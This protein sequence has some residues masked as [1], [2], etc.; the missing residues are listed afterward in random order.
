MATATADV[1]YSSTIIDT[2]RPIVVTINADQ[3]STETCIPYDQLG[4]VADNMDEMDEE[5]FFWHVVAINAVSL[6]GFDDYTTAT[7]SPHIVP[8]VE[9]IEV[10]IRDGTSGAE[11]TNVS[12]SGATVAENAGTATVSLRLSQNAAAD[13]TF[14]VN[15]ADGTGTGGT[16]AMAPSD[17][18]ALSNFDVTVPAGTDRATF[19]IAINDD[20]ISEGTE[21]FTV[22]IDAATVPA[23]YS[24]ANGTA[25]VSIMANDQNTLMVSDATVVEGDGTRTSG[26]SCIGCATARIRLQLSNTLAADLV[27]TVSSIDGGTATAGVDYTAIAATPFTIAAGQTSA[28][29]SITI[30]FDEVVEGNETFRVRVMVPLDS[31][32]MV[33]ASGPGTA[34]SNDGDA[35]VTIIDDDVATLG[36]VST[37]ATVTENAPTDQ[38]HLSLLLS[39]MLPTPLEVSLVVSVAGAG[40]LASDGIDF[41]AGT[42]MV[43]IP[44]MTLELAF[45]LTGDNRPNRMLPSIILDDQIYEQQGVGDVE[46]F[47]VTILAPSTSLV[48]L[49]DSSAAVSITDDD[50]RIEVNVATDMAGSNLL[51]NTGVTLSAGGSDQSLFLVADRGIAGVVFGPVNITAADSSL[52]T[53]TV[54]ATINYSGTPASDDMPFRLQHQFTLLPRAENDNI[55]QAAMTT[56]NVALQTAPGDRTLMNIDFSQF[57][58]VLPSTTALCGA[59]FRSLSRC[60]VRAIPVMVAD[61]DVAVLSLADVAVTRGSD[62]TAVVRFSLT[63]PLAS[64][65]VVTFS[66][67]N[68]SAT[69]GSDYT[70]LNSS[71]VTIAAGATTADVSIP[72]LNDSSNVGAETFTVR[73]TAIRPAG[74]SPASIT[75]TAG[76]VTLAPPT[77]TATVTINNRITLT[78]GDVSVSADAGSVVVPF[79]LDT[80]L[81]AGLRVLTDRNT[82]GRDPNRAMSGQDYNGINTRAAPTILAGETVPVQQINMARITILNDGVSSGSERLVLLYSVIVEGD[83]GGTIFV[84]PDGSLIDMM[85]DTNGNRRQYEA[86]ITITDPPSTLTTASALSVQRSAGSITLSFALD[87]ALSTELPIS[88]STADGT[89]TAPEDYTALSSSM[90]SITG[91]SASATAITL[92]IDIKDDGSADGDETFTVSYAA[93]VPAG[94]VVMN[95]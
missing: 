72:I 73:Y 50:R 5:S 22:S 15:T 42:Y 74:F 38:E 18:T 93:T 57:Q 41:T 16:A 46:L 31:G 68:G 90:I 39:A 3:T 69:D 94:R 44:A 35:T 21:S 27:V 11:L 63:K 25:T 34:A 56:V 59:A 66:T 82:A 85:V 91:G 26:V 48:S 2:S 19:T 6:N 43:T 10:V 37:A 29:A 23:G 24:I 92:E 7:A 83:A 86:S 9:P 55:V 52:F 45:G 75:D 88:V 64:P 4:I 33:Q 65:M 60:V 32:I 80:P 47:T 13:T 28:E 71:L 95:P 67:A 51:P 87:R 12:I 58:T 20:T 54:G 81:P 14:R 36:F 17:Y 84:F 49:G 77:G 8:M 78:V 61:D 53:I 70:A 89:A 40:N 79:S 1:D 76:T 30:Y 62:S